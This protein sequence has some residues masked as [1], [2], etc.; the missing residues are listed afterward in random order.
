MDE[1]ATITHGGRRRSSSVPLVPESEMDLVGMTNSEADM[2]A[3]DGC[4]GGHRA[5]TRATVKR[6]ATEAKAI[7]GKR[8][9]MPQ[10]H[11]LSGRGGR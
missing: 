10:W 5:L 8:K 9:R 7:A 1:A 11:S 3:G 6:T 4:D 2:E